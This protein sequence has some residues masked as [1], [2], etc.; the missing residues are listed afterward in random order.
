MRRLPFAFEPNEHGQVCEPLLHLHRVDGDCASDHG[1]VEHRALHAGRSEQRTVI[2][3]ELIDLAIEE[4]ANRWRYKLANR[5]FRLCDLPAAVD[6]DD[7]GTVLQMTKHLDEE[8][9]I[10]SRRVLQDLREVRRKAMRR[11]RKIEVAS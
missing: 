11:E 7:D 1:H 10:A 9:G 3:R 6:H 2:L 4:A 5:I 8:K